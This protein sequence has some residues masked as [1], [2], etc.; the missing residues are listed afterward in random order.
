MGTPTVSLVLGDDVYTGERVAIHSGEVT[1]HYHISGVTGSGKSSFLASI[2]LQLLNQGIGVC[3]IDPHSDLCDTILQSLIDQGFF[4]DKRA[5]QRLLY[6]DFSGPEDRYLPLNILAQPYSSHVIARNLLETFKR[7]WSGLAGGNAPMLEQ[8]LLSSVYVLAEHHLPLTALFR[9]LSEDAYRNK[10]LTS[11]TDEAVRDVFEQRYRSGAMA[12]STTRRAFLL[13]FSP[14]LRFTLG[15]RENRLS[16]RHLMDTGTSVLC[17]LGNLDE[18]TQR[19]LGSL[20]TVSMEKAAFSRADLPEATRHP[21]FMIVDEFGN[22]SET[23]SVGMEHVLAQ[24]RKYGL[25]LMLSNQTNNQIKPILSSL[26]NARRI[27]FRLGAED[28][29]NAT[30]LFFEYNPDRIKHGPTTPHG[31]P[32][33]YSQAEQREEW[34][35]KI[36]NLPSR[37]ALVRLNS[38]TRQFR[39]LLIPKATVSLSQLKAIKAQYAQRLL[40]PQTTIE[41]PQPQVIQ[42]STSFQP[43]ESVPPPTTKKQQPMPSTSAPKSRIKVQRHVP[44]SD[45]HL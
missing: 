30:P 18:D 3:L 19:F 27:V 34:E 33:Y 1:K 20:L 29:A 4:A 14:Q 37:E 41:Q 11:I 42:P 40:V 15:Q 2:F 5:F 8:L 7:S 23:T 25:H 9:F 36:A 22:F 43:S 45:E 35:Q 32:I 24:T 17:S 6:I 12:D 28:A 26:Q 16:F 44:L 21:Y 31:R 39:T 38:K 13:T 10:L